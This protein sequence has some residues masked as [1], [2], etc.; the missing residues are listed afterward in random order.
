MDARC[1]NR[2]PFYCIFRDTVRYLT[3]YLIYSYCIFGNFLCALPQLSDQYNAPSY[4]LWY[5]IIPTVKLQGKLFIPLAMISKLLSTFLPTCNCEDVV[6]RLTASGLKPVE[7]YTNIIVATHG[8][9]VT[10]NE[11]INAPRC[12][13]ITSLMNI[14]WMEGPMDCGQLL[15]ITKRQ[16]NT[17]QKW[18]YWGAIGYKQKQDKHDILLQLIKHH[19]QI[20]QFIIGLSTNTR[21]LDQNG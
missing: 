13:L 2:L 14:I 11:R 21:W 6:R 20:M 5:S 9:G 16:N 15:D 12:Q 17:C 3:A 10:R 18:C 8:S 4:I 1:E 19:I 7:V